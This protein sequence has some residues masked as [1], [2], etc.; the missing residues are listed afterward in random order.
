MFGGWRRRLGLPSPSDLTGQIAYAVESRELG[1]SDWRSLPSV[2]RAR[3]FIVSQVAQL[4]PV[5]YR[6]GLPL[7][8]QPSILRRPQP[9]A[10]MDAFLGSIA[11]ELFDR[12][13]AYLWLPVTGHNADGS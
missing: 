6:D 4:E 7:D 13:N 1:L 5:A 12:S 8:E 10:T 9:G 2:S 11:G 3:S